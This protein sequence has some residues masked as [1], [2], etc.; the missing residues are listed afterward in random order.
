M[1][2]STR[3]EREEVGKERE[4]AC[5]R[6]VGLSLKECAAH[7]SQLV[8]KW[9]WGKSRNAGVEEAKAHHSQT[10]SK[11]SRRAESPPTK[12][13]FA[14]NPTNLSAPAAPRVVLL[15]HACQSHARQA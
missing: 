3:L 1:V 5:K 9:G 11:L 10:V 6:Q 8:W 7:H 14:C 4:E 12:L 2:M 13:A 15:Y